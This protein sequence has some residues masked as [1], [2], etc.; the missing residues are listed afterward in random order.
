VPGGEEFQEGKGYRLRFD[1]EIS[2]KLPSNVYGCH[3]RPSCCF[4]WRAFVH[5]RADMP[6]HVRLW[7]SKI[8][9]PS[10]SGAVAC[11]PRD[12]R[13]ANCCF[14]RVLSSSKDVFTLKLILKPDSS[15][16]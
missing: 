11:N 12:V 1:R 16:M 13:V 7:D 9:S 3:S 6:R 14:C 15:G 5:S 2:V 8:R 10:Y 4:F